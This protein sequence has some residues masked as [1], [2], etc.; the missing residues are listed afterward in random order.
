[1]HEDAAPLVADHDPLAA[2]AAIA[3]YEIIH[4]EGGLYVDCD[5]EALRPIDELLEGASIVVGED[6]DGMLNNAFFAAGAVH[7]VLG[8]AIDELPRSF[9][10]RFHDYSVANSGRPVLD[11]MCAPGK[12][13]VRRAVDVRAA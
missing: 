12:R 7:P 9:A 4:R 2:G 6:R 3:R 1:M 5:F 10:A 11:A 8:Y 13:Q